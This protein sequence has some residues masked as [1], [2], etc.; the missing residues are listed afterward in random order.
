MVCDANR[1]N[2]IVISGAVRGHYD[3][4]PIGQIDA[5]MFGTGV[6]VTSDNVS[7]LNNSWELGIEKGAVDL[8][9]RFG[10][11]WRPINVDLVF[12]DSTSFYGIDLQS[13]ELTKNSF[14]ITIAGVEDTYTKNNIGDLVNVLVNELGVPVSAANLLPMA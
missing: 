13:T 12:G 4:F 2:N 1:T 8:E 6:T 10:T 11:D 7:G 9:V 3:G 14:T 5:E